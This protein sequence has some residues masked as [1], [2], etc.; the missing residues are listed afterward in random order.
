M[1]LTP[2]QSA[3]ASVCIHRQSS[4]LSREQAMGSRLCDCQDA[5]V[6]SSHTVFAQLVLCFL[7]EQEQPS[8]FPGSRGTRSSPGLKGAESSPEQ[9]RGFPKLPPYL[10]HISTFCQTWYQAL[11]VRAQ[12]QRSQSINAFLA[13]LEI[14]VS[15]PEA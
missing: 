7:S 13:T 8:S 11:H 2:A 9:H 3:A 1:Q 5:Q 15:K 4:E 14:F 6:F 10:D 12:I